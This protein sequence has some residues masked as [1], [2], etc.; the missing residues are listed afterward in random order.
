MKRHFVFAVIVIAIFGAAFAAHYFDGSGVNY[1]SSIYASMRSFSCN[2]ETGTRRLRLA[3]SQNEPKAGGGFDLPHISSAI[4]ITFKPILNTAA[5]QGPVV[6][7]DAVDQ[8]QLQV[9]VGDQYLPIDAI[10][11]VEFRNRTETPRALVSSE[12]KGVKREIT[13]N[14]LECL[15]SPVDR[16][17]T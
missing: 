15:V 1:S 10:K 12:L 3:W 6:V 11:T 13:A 14:L 4:Y 16:R 8:T 7:N 17:R 2:Y 5:I 9:R